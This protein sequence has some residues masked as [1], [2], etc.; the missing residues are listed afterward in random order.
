MTRTRMG[1]SL[2]SASSAHFDWS[3]SR[4]LLQLLG[5]LHVHPLCYLKYKHKYSYQWRG[6]LVPKCLIFSTK[7]PRLFLAED[8]SCSFLGNMRASA[9]SHRCLRAGGGIEPYSS[10]VGRQWST[11][12]VSGTKFSE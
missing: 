7:P 1:G 5:D 2:E 6:W 4:A 10:L 11:S 12:Q 9:A 3:G 8:K